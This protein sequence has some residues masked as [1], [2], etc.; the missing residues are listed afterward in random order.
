[1]RPNR[2]QRVNDEVADRRVLLQLLRA[3]E[4]DLL[5]MILASTTSSTRRRRRSPVLGVERRGCRSRRRNGRGGAL[6][7]V[8]IASMTMPLSISFSRATA[9]AMAKQPACWQ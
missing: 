7:G 8:S 1:M 3:L 6:D 2:R 5:E 4:V 9:S